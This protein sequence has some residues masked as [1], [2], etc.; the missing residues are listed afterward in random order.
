MESCCNLADAFRQYEWKGKPW[1]ENFAELATYRQRLRAAMAEKNGVA[2]FEACDAILRSGGVWANNGRT[3]TARRE[4]LL[5]ELG[6]V[7][8]VPMSN[9]TPTELEMRLRD[10]ACSMNSGFVKI[11]SVLLDSC[12]IYDGRVGAALGLLARQYCEEERLEAAFGPR[13]CLWFPER[14]R[15]RE[16]SEAQKSKPRGVSISRT[17]TERSLP[18]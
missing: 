13:V 11:Y 15:E 10:D 12:V 4:C 17:S 14:G 9:H 16:V 8:A 1:F 18:H 3:L 5:E 7:K 6:H 2:A